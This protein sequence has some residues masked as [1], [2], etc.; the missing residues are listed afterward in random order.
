MNPSEPLTHL[1]IAECKIF[2][3][4]YE[5]AKLEIREALRLGWHHPRAYAL[6][7]EVYLRQRNLTK[8]FECFFETVRLR[9]LVFKDYLKQTFLQLLSL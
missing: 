7:S 2:E 8:A 4:R 1:G 6:L 3:R 9:A 5:E